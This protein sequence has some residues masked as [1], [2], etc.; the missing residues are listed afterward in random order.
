VRV[1]MLHHDP[2]GGHG[3]ASHMA[4]RTADALAG[5]GHDVAI[6]GT[7]PAGARRPDGGAPVARRLAGGIPRTL[8]DVARA[9]GWAP[10]VVHVT[11]LADATA[12]TRG[13]ALARSA[14][15]AFALTPATDA[16]LWST[17][18]LAGRVARQ[19]DVVFALTPTERRALEALGVPT[20]R[21]AHLGQGPQ[22]TGTPDPDGFRARH[23]VRGPLVLFLGRKLPT[24][25]HQH[26]IAAAP[27]ILARHPATTVVVAGPEPRRPAVRRLASACA[28]GLRHLAGLALHHRIAVE[29][30]G[31]RELGPLDE[32]D[33]HSALAAADVLCLPSVADAFPL[34]FVE[35]WWCATPVVSGPFPGAGEVV[36]DGVDGLIAPADPAGVASAIDRLL[37]EPERRRAMGLAGRLRAETELSWDI[38]AADAE[39]GYQRA[40]RSGT[41][42]SASPSTP[43][44]T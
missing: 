37:A 43:T 11:D 26:L 10:D 4:W 6:A 13:L 29:A 30:S 38:V 31:L 33:K 22:L 32:G 36:R 1:L 16:A 27:A 7:V 25:G 18:A 15:A 28:S 35:A 44:A 12:A 42:P 41:R 8:A 23:G 24:K 17:P 20:A 39:R 19:A 34:V 2:A 3:G 40:A 21:L 9:T 14:G 5:R